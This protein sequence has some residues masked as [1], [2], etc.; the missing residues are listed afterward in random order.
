VRPN[1]PERP[2]STHEQETPAT[3]PRPESDADSDADHDAEA[4]LTG[5]MN[6]AG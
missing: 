3:M 1:R 6:D 2:G 5:L 4:R